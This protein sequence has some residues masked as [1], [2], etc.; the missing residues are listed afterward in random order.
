MVDG[1][2]VTAIRDAPLYFLLSPT[3]AQNSDC[4]HV[5]HH[6]PYPRKRGRDVGDAEE[7]L[8]HTWGRCAEV[9]SAI[10]RWS[11]SAEYAQGLDLAP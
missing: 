2:R 10:E 3:K 6:D 1:K 4:C 8:V 5:L 7:H 11:R 9:C